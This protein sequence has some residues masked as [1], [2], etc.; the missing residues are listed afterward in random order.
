MYD[1]Y[2]LHLNN[3]FG[4]G[5]GLYVLYNDVF[6]PRKSGSWG[7]LEYLDQPLEEAPKYRA[8]LDF[9]RSARRR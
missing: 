1:V 7:I 5:G 9:I 2:V 4:A 3:W 8:V 6:R